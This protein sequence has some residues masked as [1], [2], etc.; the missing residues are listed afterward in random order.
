MWLDSYFYSLLSLLFFYGLLENFP[1]ENIDLRNFIKS[2][3]RVVFKMSVKI[4]AEKKKV[5]LGGKLS[6]HPESISISHD[7]AILKH[8]MP[9]Y[10]I[11]TNIFKIC[12]CKWS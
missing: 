4:P 7:S 5:I 1:V 8:R 3:V 2:P 12:R 10:N 9:T 11:L 6:C